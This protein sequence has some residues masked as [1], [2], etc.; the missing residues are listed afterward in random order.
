MSSPELISESTQLQHDHSI[1]LLTLSTAYSLLSAVSLIQLTRI[2]LRVPEYGWT[3]QKVF[4]LMSA[5]VNGVRAATFRSSMIIVV[6]RPKVLTLVLLHLPVL[7][8]FTTFTLLVRFWAEIYYQA[9]SVSSNWPGGCY[10]LV[11]CGIYVIQL[12]IWVYLWMKDESLVG[13]ISQLFVT[14]TSFIGALGFLLYGSR[15]FF[16][17]KRFPIESKG[18]QR[19]LYEVGSLTVVCV[20]SF[21][22]RCVMVGMSA[23]DANASQRVINHPLRDLIYYMLTE[24]LP[25]AF[26]LFTVR[27]LPPK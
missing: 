13:S 15:L 11:N 23:F 16:M 12:L 8:F 2:Q 18:R 21:L 27:K 10:I 7:F 22:V 26:V 25:S 3:T 1:L 19:K 20:T 24:I 9:K 17:L 6:L 5:V 14:V 4:H